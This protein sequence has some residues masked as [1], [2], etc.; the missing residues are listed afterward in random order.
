MNKL[1]AMDDDRRRQI[2]E[3]TSAQMNLAEVAVEKDFWVCWT[4]DKLF[5]LPCGQHLTFKGGTSLSKAWHLIERFSEDIDITIHRDALGFGGDNAPHAAPSKTQRKKRL[6]QLK[7]ACERYIA[8]TLATELHEVIV[9]DLPEENAWS[10]QLDT[11]DRQTLLFEYPSVIPAHRKRAPMTDR[12]I[13]QY[14][15]DLETW[16]SPA[17]R[18]HPDVHDEF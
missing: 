3:Q 1:L 10:L 17:E 18:G 6:K 12:S 9:A 11:D 4:L 16:I 7:A 13:R 15:S 14:G 5:R 8:G 2:F